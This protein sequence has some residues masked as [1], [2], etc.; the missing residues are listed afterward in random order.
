MNWTT[1]ENGDYWKIESNLYNLVYNYGY[2]WEK[3]FVRV[4]CKDVVNQSAL[5]INDV[6]YEFF[7]DDEQIIVEIT[8]LIRAYP[9]GT[10]TFVQDNKLTV[11][12]LDYISLTGQKPTAQNYSKLPAEIPYSSKDSNPFYVQLYEKQDYLKNDTT[13]AALY[14][15]L[16]ISAVDVKT[17]T[18]FA[19]AFRYYDGPTPTTETN[20]FIELDCTTDKVLVEWISRFGQLKSWWFTI[21][22]M[23]YSSDKQIDL[24]TLESGYNSMKNKRYGLIISHKKADIITQQYLSDIVVSDSV[25]IY[26]TD[27]LQVKVET[28]AFEIS[29]RK[30]DIIIVI[31]KN[32]YDTI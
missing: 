15:S 32:S 11:Y 20:V 2:T 26:D 13:W 5:T 23:I 16:P 14:N 30:Q 29:K 25:Y 1:H 9:T 27:K 31:N 17:L 6:R 28:N 18:D 22:K 19:G 10:I 21:E 3:S 8:D 12:E 4:T 24:Q 7:V